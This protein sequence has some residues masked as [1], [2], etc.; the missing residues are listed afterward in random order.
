MTVAAT[1][2][3]A[4]IGRGTAR[5]IAGE[6]VADLESGADALRKRSHAGARRG[7]TGDWLAQ[8]WGRID[9]AKGASIEVPLYEAETVA[10]RLEPGKGQ[11]PPLVVATLRGTSQTARYSA[12]DGAFMYRS[13]PRDVVR[14]FELVQS[15]SR[16]LVTGVRGGAAAPT[17]R[18][19]RHGAL[20]PHGRGTERWASTFARARSASA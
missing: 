16:Y 8:L 4:P 9:R 1:P 13:T 18:G 19:R 20:Q 6:L 7:A 3:L 11:G 17:D 2:G 12:G 10:L 15:G 14:A 5:R